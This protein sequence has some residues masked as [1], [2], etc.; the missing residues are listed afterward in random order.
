MSKQ[1]LITRPEHD[2]TLH[3]LSAWSAAIIDNAKLHG[4]R[5]LDL[6]RERATK[7]D[8]ESMIAKQ[9]PELVMFNGHGNKETICGHKN[10][11]IIEADKNEQILKEKIVLAISCSSAS[12]LGDKAVDKGTKAFIGYAEDFRFYHDI[13]KTS[14]PLTD[15]VAKMYLDPPISIALSLLKGHTAKEAHEKAIS[16]FN[17][18]ISKLLT[19]EAP[20]E[21]SRVV[22]YLWWDAINQTVK[23]DLSATI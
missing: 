20:E 17:D 11:P 5:V 1:L 12:T 10:E 23:G 19:Q 6:H 2:T 7:K 13:T 22:Q 4:V 3:Y 18:A 21:H 8:V 14:R 15:D 9:E 16:M